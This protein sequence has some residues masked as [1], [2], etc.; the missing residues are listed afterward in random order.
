MPLGAPL[1]QCSAFLLFSGTSKCL[2]VCAVVYKWFLM[3]T[4]GFHVC[5]R[6]HLGASKYIALIVSCV[7]RTLVP[8]S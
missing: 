2:S 5:F 6:A 4:M 1:G 8:C 3:S 7:Q